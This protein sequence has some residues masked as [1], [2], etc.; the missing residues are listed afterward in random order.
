VSLMSTNP[1]LQPC[2]SYHGTA[3]LCQHCGENLAKAIRNPRDRFRTSCSKID[4]SP[5][6]PAPVKSKSAHAALAIPASLRRVEPESI[7]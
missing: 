3:S 5:I 6:G 1:P 7:S 2:F 4:L